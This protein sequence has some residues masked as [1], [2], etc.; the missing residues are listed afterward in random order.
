M[1]VALVSGYDW[2]VPGGVQGQV[3]AV[4]G[5][6]AAAGDEVLVVT[7]RRS[8]GGPAP[9]GVTV[10]RAGRGIPVPVNGSVAPVA[11]TPWAA[12]AALA[13]LRRFRPEV[14]H[15]HEPL[16]PGPPLAALLRGRVPIV[17]T[18]H[19]AE[20]DRLY[21]LEGRLLGSA[22]CRRIGRATAVSEAAAATAAEVLGPAIGRCEIVPNGVD[23]ARFARAAAARPPAPG[24]WKDPGGPVVA[25]VSRLEHRKGASVLLEAAARLDPGVRVVVAGDGPEAAAL[26]RLAPPGRVEFPGRLTDGQV[27][28]L[29]AA[30]DL[31]VA[32]AIGGESFGVILL[33]AMAA[34]TAV[35]AS[36][37]PGYELAAAGAA[38]LFPAGDPGALAAAIGDLL[39]DHEARA[40]LVLA[41]AERARECSIDSVAARYRQCYLAL[42]DRP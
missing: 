6:L 28:E 39:A 34:E 23:G 14:V 1:R 5:A 31:F 35:V 20:A 17:A 32:P 18:F 2:S 37:L 21:R 26:R 13:A 40:A 24:P 10:R 36:D 15:L 8:G 22:A 42:L 3:A 12:G 38:R 19:R 4:A 27:A 7:P 41:G 16:V 30:A 11:P 33:E 9:A 29:M 25:F